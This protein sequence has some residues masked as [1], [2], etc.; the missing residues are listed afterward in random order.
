[1]AEEAFHVTLLVV[2]NALL[3]RG[4]TVL[5]PVLLIIGTSVLFPLFLLY[6]LVADSFKNVRKEFLHPIFQ[7]FRKAVPSG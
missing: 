1:M 7:I 5:R 3:S 2:H 6:Y 4:K